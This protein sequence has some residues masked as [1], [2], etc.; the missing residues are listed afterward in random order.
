[1]EDTLIYL[2]KPELSRVAR[3][4]QITLYPM[5][6]YAVTSMAAFKTG[7]KGTGDA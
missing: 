2:Q 1:M 3:L 7:R 4:N 5:M 6:K